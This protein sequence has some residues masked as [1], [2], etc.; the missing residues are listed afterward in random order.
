MAQDVRQLQLAKSAIRAGLETLLAESGLSTEQIEHFYIA[1]GFGKYIDLENAAKIGLI[2][3]SLTG[4]ASALGNAAGAG[5]SMILLSTDAL[6]ESERIAQ[7]AEV[8]ELSNSPIFMEK[9][10]EYMGFP[11]AAE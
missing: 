1:G 2:S 9:Y 4:K 11:G 3:P 5:A 6:E 8:A 10:M 7:M